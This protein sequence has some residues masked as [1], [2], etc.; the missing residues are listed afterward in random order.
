MKT[1]RWIDEYPEHLA[2]TFVSRYVRRKS[3]FR[4]VSM[5]KQ[6]LIKRRKYLVESSSFIAEIVS[7]SGTRINTFWD[8]SHNNYTLMTKKTL[9]LIHIVDVTGFC[10][11][12]INFECFFFN[13]EK[14]KWRCDS[15]LH[16]SRQ[17]WNPYSLYNTFMLFRF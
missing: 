17:K 14:G 6:Y 10:F 12:F 8:W 2:S 13:G 4:L 16:D 5:N 1:K 11:F 9:L 15:H 3:T 7:Y